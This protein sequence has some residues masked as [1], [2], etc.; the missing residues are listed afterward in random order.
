MKNLNQTPTLILN[1]PR[2]FARTATSAIGALQQPA[3]KFSPERSATRP[4]YQQ[5]QQQARMAVIGKK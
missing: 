4:T 2:I 3:Q 5:Q 1:A